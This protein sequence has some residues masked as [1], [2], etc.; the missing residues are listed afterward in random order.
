M[1]HLWAVHFAVRSHLCGLCVRMGLDARYLVVAMS[2][3]FGRSWQN[4]MIFATQIAE[5][6]LNVVTSVTQIAKTPQNAMKTTT[7]IAQTSQNAMKTVTP[8]AKAL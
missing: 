4:A 5:T 3:R 7:Q 6:L 2:L 8:M 1:K